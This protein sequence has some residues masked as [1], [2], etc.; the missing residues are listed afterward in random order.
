MENLSLNSKSLSEV[1]RGD[2]VGQDV[3][4]TSNAMY[5][6]KSKMMEMMDDMT[7]D[8]MSSTCDMVSKHKD[9]MRGKLR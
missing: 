6:M 2:M 3:S 1:V 4:D 7:C 8:E 9:Q 5:K